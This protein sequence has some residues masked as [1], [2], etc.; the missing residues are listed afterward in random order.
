MELWDPTETGFLG[1]SCRNQTKVEHQCQLSSFWWPSSIAPHTAPLP[2]LYQDSLKLLTQQPD[3]W[4]QR[5]TDIVTLQKRIT[6]LISHHWKFGK[7]VFKFTFLEG[8][9]VSSQEDKD[10]FRVNQALRASIQL[11]RLKHVESCG[12]PHN[13]SWLPCMFL[14][15]E[16]WNTSG[17]KT[18]Q[19]PRFCWE[20]KTSWQFFVTFLGKWQ[21]VTR[22]PPTR[23]T[24]RS[25]FESAGFFRGY[26]PSF[27]LN[28]PLNKAWFIP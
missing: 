6:Y 24:K 21:G 18:T 5:I 23:K 9:P 3:E 16:K 10:H 28:N 22:Q 4:L 26:E 12:N 7:V 11:N 15:A 14:V 1:P 25:R 20:K 13:M 8:R 19:T 2:D 17:K 27:S